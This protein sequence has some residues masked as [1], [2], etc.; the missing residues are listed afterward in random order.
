[1][2]Y[3]GFSTPSI[4]II[5]QIQTLL[6]ERYKEGFPVIKEIIQNANDGGASTLHI[7]LVQNLKL[8]SLNPDISHPLLK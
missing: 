4:A 5:N 2:S 6:K 1:M 3:T 7:A 8:Q